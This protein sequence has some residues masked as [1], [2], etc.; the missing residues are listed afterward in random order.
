MRVIK[1]KK[2]NLTLREEDIEGFLERKVT[3]FGNSG[4][5]DC[6]KR[7]MGRRLYLIVCKE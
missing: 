7:Y 6:P 3:P 2:G 5:V 4:K 1:L